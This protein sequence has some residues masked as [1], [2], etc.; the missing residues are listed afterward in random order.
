MIYEFTWLRSRNK[1]ARVATR[2]CI[3]VQ[4][5]APMNVFIGR[6]YSELKDWCHGKLIK[7]KCVSASTSFSGDRK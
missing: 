1:K 5:D 3:V 2:N 4:A 7:S 6:P